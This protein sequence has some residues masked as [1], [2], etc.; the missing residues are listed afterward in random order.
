MIWSIINL[1][2]YRIAS[3]VADFII[4]NSESTIV[5]HGLVSQTSLKNRGRFR[6]AES[7]S[8]RDNWSNTGL[9]LFS[10]L[11]KF[12][13]KVICKSKGVRDAGT[14]TISL[15]FKSSFTKATRI[16]AEKDRL[17]ARLHE[18]FDAMSVSYQMEDYH[19][20]WE[21][22]AG[23]QNGPYEKFIWFGICWQ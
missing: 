17:S 8:L 7:R 20:S 13:Q 3:G 18:T 23:T 10:L 14:D 4:R 22:T 11:K 9:L 5:I 2:T 19:I 15:F 21:N 1:P 12:R 6:N 16:K